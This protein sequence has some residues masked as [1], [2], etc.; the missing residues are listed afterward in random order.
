MESGIV[1]LAH[2]GQLG[3]LKSGCSVHPK[4]FGEVGK[5]SYGR[6]MKSFL[7]HAFGVRGYRH[8]RTRYEKGTIIFE[9]EPEEEP[10]IPGGEKLMR[11]GFRWREVRTVGIGLK[12]VVLRVK[13]QRWLNTT[14]GVEFEQSPPFVEAYT[15]VTRKLGRMIVDLA[16]FMTL[17]DV[18]GWLGLSWDTV[19]TV[20]KKRL[21][22]D[23]RR[24]GY[25]GVR[26]IAIDEIY[27]G[28]THKYITLVM[29]MKSGR[30]IW[31]G[32]GRGGE[33]LREFWR[34]FKLSGGRLQAVAMDMSGA[35]AASVRAHAPHAILTFDRFHVIKLMN[36]RLDDLRREL[37]REAQDPATKESI[38]GL[39]WL[40]LHRADNLEKDAAARLERSLKINEPLQCA[41]L[42]KE[43]LGELW[44][45]SDGR[46]AWAF[47]REWSAKV[48]ASGTR[49]LEAMAKTLRR[50]AKGIL[51]FYKTGLTSG[52]ME[53]TNR[54]IRGLL[55]SAYGF[56]DSDFL[57][58]RLYALHEAKFNFVG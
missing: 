56:R 55:A 46:K 50:H 3:G 43:E 52:K 13:V 6:R 22:K 24:I 8:L 40:L 32:Q 49:Q 16:R 39:R 20:V 48:K 53:G 9:M 12:P 23:Y 2:C 25:R 35:Y 27:L 57:K 11:R 30:I 21:E 54:K 58:L 33:A 37:V 1:S 17:S 7:Y 10:E 18:A 42:L 28:R 31:V 41:Y 4:S 38:K 29:D 15:K 5:S 34:R 44:T 47:L 45:Q 19:K 14:T 26:Q 51:S 36:E